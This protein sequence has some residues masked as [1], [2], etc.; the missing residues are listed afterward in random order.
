[1]ITIRVA[2]RVESQQGVRF[3]E[4]HNLEVEE[5]NQFLYFEDD[6]GTFLVIAIGEQPL[7][8]SIIQRMAAGG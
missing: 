7:P 3:W 5:Q 2:C 4:Y 8:E 1:M 6:S